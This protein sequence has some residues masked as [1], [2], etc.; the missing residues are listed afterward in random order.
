[1]FI[2]FWIFIFINLYFIKKIYMKNIIYLECVMLKG[3]KYKK[4][5]RIFILFWMDG[6]KVLFYGIRN[7]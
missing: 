1:M 6:S 7:I 5:K 4:L 2:K 3:I